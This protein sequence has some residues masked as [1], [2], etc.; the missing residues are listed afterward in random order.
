MLRKNREL[1]QTSETFLLS[2]IL[3]LSGGFQDAYTYNARDEVFSNAQTGNVVLMS[4]HLMMGDFK[5]ALRYLFPLI[6]F[7]LGVLVAERISHRYKNASRIHW[8]Q[9]VVLVEI[10]ILFHTGEVQS[11]RHDACVICLFHAGS[12]FQK[13]KWLRLCQHDVYRK[14]PKRNGESVGIPQGQ[15]AWGTQKGHALLWN[16]HHIRT[17]RR[18][19][20]RVHAASGVQVD[21]DIQCTSYGGTSHDV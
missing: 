17:W 7:A 10:V 8:R 18:S 6:A 16:H 20:R 12:D 1:R 13:G 3:A 15:R 11:A 5:I 21:L 14:S 4:Q 2:A 19:W 9:I